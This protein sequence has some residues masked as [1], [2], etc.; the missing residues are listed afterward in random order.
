MYR[1]KRFNVLK[2]AT[3][4]AVMYMVLVAIFVVPFLLL[5]TF[6]GVVGSSQAQGGLGAI[7]GVGLFAIFAYG[8][9]GWILTAIACL[10][11]N[12]VAA[13]IGGIEV[14]V[15][16]VAPPA[17]PPAWITSP[18][19]PGPPSPSSTPPAV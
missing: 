7:L 16:A 14:Q 1:I 19:P 3:V 17:P 6:V 4:V 5:F 18:A 12:G 11:Y 15:E 9:L 8:I 10:I 2:T 13:W